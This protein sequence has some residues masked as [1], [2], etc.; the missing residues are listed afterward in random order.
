[1]IPPLEPG[2]RAWHD[3]NMTKTPSTGG[4]PPNTSLRFFRPGQYLFREGEASRCMYL[5]KKGT[6]SIRKMKGPAYVEIAR[7]YSKE[8]LGELSFFDRNPR[9]A[10]AVAISEVEALEIS[11]ESLDKIYAGVPDYLKT[12]IASVAERLRKADDT[13]RRLQ[14]NVITDDGR[15]EKLPRKK[16][17]PADPEEEEESQDL[18]QILKAT[19]GIVA[20]AEAAEAKSKSEDSAT[21]ES[22]DE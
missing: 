10:A 8:V 12:I 9:S 2:H 21:D 3:W 20:E 1:M 5:I 18:S 17:E 19:A 6:V 22:E 15:E 4:A 11:F 7:I 16:G 13:I 14:R